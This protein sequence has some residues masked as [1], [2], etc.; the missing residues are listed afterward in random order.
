MYTS[1]IE[2]TVTVTQREL[3]CHPP[4]GYTSRVH[5]VLIGNDCD[6]PF[7]LG[8][9][10]VSIIIFVDSHYYMFKEEPCFLNT[11]KEACRNT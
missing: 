8:D 5:I 4:F 2:Q 3:H 11:Q 7:E 10:Y 9:I 1:C 6:T